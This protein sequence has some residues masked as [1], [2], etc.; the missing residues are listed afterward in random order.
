MT[1]EHKPDHYELLGLGLGASPAEVLRTAK[2]IEE[3][4]LRRLEQDHDPKV[5]ARIESDL[6]ASREAARV[7]ADPG[8]RAQYDAHLRTAT[9][10]G[11]SPSPALIQFPPEPSAHLCDLLERR[12]RDLGTKGSVLAKVLK[13]VRVSS[14][15]PGPLDSAHAV[16]GDFRAGAYQVGKHAFERV[17]RE[18]MSKREARSLEALYRDVVG[19]LHA[20]LP[21]AERTRLDVSVPER[22]LAEHRLEDPRRPVLTPVGTSVVFGALAVVLTL[23]TVFF[24]VPMESARDAGPEFAIGDCMLPEGTINVLADC[25]EPGAMEV[26]AMMET[27]DDGPWPGRPYLEDQSRDFCLGQAPDWVYM[28]SHSFPTL[29]AWEAGD[30]TIAC[31]AERPEYG[32]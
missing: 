13:S 7:L 1:R 17:S 6:E 9:P 15:R 27:E 10:E 8:L 20:A 5:R 22:V 26:Y 24:F 19:G 4:L 31:S 12:A 2:L 14:V 29:A 21:E 11:A 16:G 3:S 18:R 23:A 28:V 25:S 32:L 30:R